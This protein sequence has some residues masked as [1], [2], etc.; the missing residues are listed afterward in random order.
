MTEKKKTINLYAKDEQIVNAAIDKIVVD[1]FNKRDEEDGGQAIVLTGCSP[2]AGVTSTSIELGIAMASSQRKTL[3]IDCDVRKGIKYKK[4]NEEASTGL[5]D[6]LLNDDLKVEDAIYD[7]N[8]ENLSYMPCG[9][10]S[11]HSTRV[12]CSPKMNDLIAEAREKFDCILLDIPSITIVPDAQILFPV[13]DG[14]ILLSALGETRKKQIKE[15]KMKVAPFASKYYGMIVNKIPMDVYRQ[16][17]KD[18]DYY[19]VDKK[20]EQNLHKS[21]AYQNY[22]KKRNTRH[23]GGKNNEKNN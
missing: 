16:N 14:I 20:G 8:I 2:L 1:L 11:E 10:Y 6:Y 22:K 5:A 7:T 13:V 18:Y 12:L 3:V 9:E 21:E 15:A 4:L 23:A 17:V 19:F